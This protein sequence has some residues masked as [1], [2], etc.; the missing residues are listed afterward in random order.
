MYAGHVRHQLWDKDAFDLAVQHSSCKKLK[1]LGLLEE[2]FEEVIEEIGAKR[3]ACPH[4]GLGRGSVPMHGVCRS[5][6]CQMNCSHGQ[7]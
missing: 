1:L 2:V 5:F 3:D 6:L 7:L 4:R